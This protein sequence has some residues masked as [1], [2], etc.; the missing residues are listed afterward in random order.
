MPAV[1][2][3]FPSLAK[4]FPQQMHDY[5]GEASLL[6]LGVG[7]R[8]RGWRFLAPVRLFRA[9][10]T[11]FLDL[12]EQEAPLWGKTSLALPTIDQRWLDDPPLNAGMSLLGHGPTLEERSPKGCRNLERGQSFRSSFP[13]FQD[14]TSKTHVV[15]EGLAGHRKANFKVYL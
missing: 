11:S 12:R 13:H 6:D 3:D 2:R 10:S 9:K 5:D 4:S 14:L 8:T 15:D 7:R 1:R